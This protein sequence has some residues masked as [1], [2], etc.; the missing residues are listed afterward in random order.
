MREP[1]GKS[2]FVFVFVFALRACVLDL[3]EGLYSRS[4]QGHPPRLRRGLI[5]ERSNGSGTA[6]RAP[7][8]GLR[9]PTGKSC[10]VFVFAFA[11]RAMRC[12]ALRA[13]GGCCC[14]CV[15]V[16]VCESVRGDR[17]FQRLPRRPNAEPIVEDMPIFPRAWGLLALAWLGGRR[18]LGG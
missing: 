9:E 10:F 13:S 8:W 11:L 7:G 4:F 17:T 14:C 15:C 2:C 1:T 5:L 6:E 12:D 3:R 18:R 16:C